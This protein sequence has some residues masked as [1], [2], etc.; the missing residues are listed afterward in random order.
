MPAPTGSPI[1]S[2]SSVASVQSVASVKSAAS[3]S[4]AATKSTVP[5]PLPTLSKQCYTSSLV[6]CK[7]VYSPATACPTTTEV[8]PA[9]CG[10]PSSTIASS[11]TSFPFM[12][13]QVTCFARD[14]QSTSPTIISIFTNDVAFTNDKGQGGLLSHI[15]A[16]CFLIIKDSVW[17]VTTVAFELLGGEWGGELWFSRASLFFSINKSQEVIEPAKDL[18]CIVLAIRSSGG[19]QE[20]PVCNQTNWIPS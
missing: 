9:S 7:Y 10:T 3:V 11:P 14:V 2:A 4:S 6:N 16:T 12:P 1:P 18:S 19:P 20:P 13:P 15:E 8:L 17:N 5:P